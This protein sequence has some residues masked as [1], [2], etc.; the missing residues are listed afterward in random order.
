V[1][2]APNRFDEHIWP[3]LAAR[4]PAFE[5][6]RVRSGWAGYCEMNTFDH[7]GLVGALPG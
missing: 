1:S 3:T 7:N 2:G 4:I 5:V 6:L